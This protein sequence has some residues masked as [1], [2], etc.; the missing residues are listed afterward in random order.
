MMATRSRFSELP[1]ESIYHD[2]YEIAFTGLDTPFIYMLLNK[3]PM[4]LKTKSKDSHAKDEM[5]L[6]EELCLIAKC[7]R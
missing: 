7:R 3:N 1:M 5:S 4:E 2:I 6:L